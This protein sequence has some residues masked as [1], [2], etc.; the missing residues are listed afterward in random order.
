[1][2]TNYLPLVVLALAGCRQAT[3]P[4]IAQ[5]DAPTPIQEVKRDTPLDK[6]LARPEAVYRWENVDDGEWVGGDANLRL[7]SQTWQ[8]KPW[9][10]RLQI[11]RPANLR[12]PEAAILNISF[13]SGSIPETFIGQQLANA[14]GAT[15]VN[16]FNVPN[17]P[18]YGKIED[19]LIAYTLAKYLETGD[20]TWPLLFPMTKSVTKSMDALQDW[21]EQNGAKITK[22]VVTGASKRGWTTDLVAATDTRVVG[23][24][25]I[26]YNNLNLPA[27]I[28]HQKEVWTTTSPMMAPYANS[29]LF[30]QTNTDAGKQL[31]EMI[32]PWSYRSRLTMPKLLI[33]ATND[34]YWPHD[35]SSLYRAELPGQTDMF[36]VP[37]A[38]HI[39]GANIT[40]AIGS[41]AAWTNLLLD[42]KA[43]PKLSL[44]VEDGDK[45]RV[46]SL[47]T[48]G[49]PRIARLWLA[50]SGSKDFRNAK[51]RSVELE[52]R[53]GGY[54]ATVTEEALYPGGAKYAA[55]F[56]EI[57]VAAQPLPL[58][59]STD[60]WEG[61]K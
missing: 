61:E 6:Y 36:L 60:V 1:M 38:P 9:T 50:S 31:M 21:S 47:S 27:Q 40:A 34:G 2:K 52:P 41:A 25:P 35:A 15:V 55:A 30:D 24:I 13:G 12:H 8:G 11:F 19:D 37:N 10:H 20:E 33:S 48:D 54:K 45:G 32:D 49:A 56:G 51:W 42:S 57:E 3:V 44:K 7:I 18:I 39:L 16:V 14:T 46:F 26:V 5:N 53:D 29:G 23:A 58:R 28:A 59:L 17:Q 43:T 4:A 22:F